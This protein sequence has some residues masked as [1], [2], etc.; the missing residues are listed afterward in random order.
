[1][2]QNRIA[3]VAWD[4]AWQYH[5]AASHEV[6]VDTGSR[7]LWNRRE[8]TIEIDMKRPFREKSCQD[9]VRTTTR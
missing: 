3:Y 8:N 2:T 9:G 6:I 1:M 4:D 5:E 7:M